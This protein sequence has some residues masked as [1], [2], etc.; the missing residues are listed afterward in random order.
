MQGP[1]TL[2]VGGNVDTFQITDDGALWW[3]HVDKDGNGHPSVQVTVEGTHDVA[4]CDPNTGIDQINT[5]FGPFLTASRKETRPDEPPTFWQ[6]RIVAYGY[7][8]RLL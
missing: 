1:R 3:H 4:W 2:L 6:I 5:V 7:V 8:A